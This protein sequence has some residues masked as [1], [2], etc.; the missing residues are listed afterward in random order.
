[1]S[2]SVSSASHIPKQFLPL[3][4][5]PLL[6]HTT[7]RFKKAIPNIKI[8]VVL[9]RT[10]LNY[11]K[12]ICKKYNVKIQH[13]VVVGGLTRFHSVK[14]GLKLITDKK[15][16]VAVHDGVRP[17][18][19]T[20]IIRRAFRL[21]EKKGNA[22]P[23][24]PINDSLRINKGTKNYAIDRSFYQIVQTPQ[25]F[26]IQLLRK[27]YKQSYKKIFTDDA[28]VLEASGEPIN[29]IKGDSK[30]IKITSFQDILLAEALI[31]YRAEV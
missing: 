11:W 29:L 7:L 23:V 28:S 6:I 16:I 19:N 18:V 31:N 24:I 8:I 10:Q 12:N 26:D 4:G 14:N 2:A 25:C 9:P 20:E 17:L 15:G 1:M 3:A 13:S 22:V 21:A 30:N 27:A 5:I